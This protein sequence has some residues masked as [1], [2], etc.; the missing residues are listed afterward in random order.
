MEK[1]NLTNARIVFP[2]KGALKEKDVRI[3]SGTIVEIADRSNLASGGSTIDLDGHYL[4]PGFIDLQVNGAGGVDFLTCQS[5]DLERASEFLL[6]HGTTSFLGTIITQP[7]EAMNAAVTK[8]SGANMK[9]LLGIHIEGPFLS[10]LARGTHNASHVLEPDLET[11]KTITGDKEEDIRLF[12]F[13]PELKKAKDLLGW[14][15]SI[16]ALP[17]VGHSKA[18]YDTVNE[19]LD[20]G[21]SSFTHLFNGMENFHHRNPG[22]VGAALNSGSF[23]GIIADGQHL[24]PATVEL[25]KNAKDSER[26]YL[27]TDAIAAAGM[28]EGR[29]VLGDQP[30]I[31]NDRLARLDNGTIA[32]STL[33][34]EKAARNYMKFTGVSLVDAVKAV[35]VNPAKLLGMED[36]IG[37]MDLGSRADFVVF[38]RKLEVRTVII[39]GEIVYDGES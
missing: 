32:G 3:E 24:H 39:D 18:S 31:V 10:K 7:P 27:V 6:T 35:T 21:V 28:D 36:E 13:A 30:I 33:T 25:V 38:D 23:V 1:L 16:G 34:L 11:F 37:T 14:I 4:A 17:S 22:P 2:E 12:T 19:F 29:Y 15:Q 8:L 20:L 9:N 5:D 26:V